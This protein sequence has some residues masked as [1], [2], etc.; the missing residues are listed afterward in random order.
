[1][2]VTLPAMPRSIILCIY[3]DAESGVA[4]G[5]PVTST[6]LDEEGVINEKISQELD[7]GI[8][9]GVSGRACEQP[10]GMVFWAERHNHSPGD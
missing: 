5:F 9:R 2:G 8:F 6:P 1:M 3:I 10:G 4:A 7:T